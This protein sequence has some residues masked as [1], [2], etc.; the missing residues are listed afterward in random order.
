MLG[1]SMKKSLLKG[2]AHL[3]ARMGIN[4]SKGQR[5]ELRCEPEVADFAYFVVEECYKLGA[6]KVEVLFES[7]E[8]SRLHIEYREEKILA[9]VENWEEERLK[10]RLE[11]L[12]ATIY[13][14][15][16]DPDGLVGIDQEKYGRST[17]ER[18]KVIKP[19]R[20][21]MDN[22]YPWCIAAVPGKAWAKKMFPELT[23]KKAVER[24][25]EAILYTSRADG[26]NPVKAWQ[27]HNRSLSE[28][29]RYLNS[30]GIETLHYVSSNGT[31]LT[32]GMIPE[33]RF[34]AGA[35]ATLSG[36]VFNPNIPSEEVFIS[37]KK[38]EAEGIVYSSKP[39]SYRGELIENFSLRF[40]KGRVVE[41]HA[42]KNE[43]LLK[44][45][46]SMDEGASYLGECALVPYDSPISDTGLLFYNTL[47]DEN[48]SCHLA[49][50]EGFT[51]TLENYETLTLDD[52]R[53]LGINE[54]MVHEDFM[55]GTRD[56]SIT[57]HTRDGREV[58][59]FRNGNWA[60]DV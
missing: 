19:Y 60:F 27:E 12:P 45:L 32:V 44:I 26:D 10:Y 13:L 31:D 43:E 39:L 22:K 50:G 23:P 42:E 5:V 51:N 37:P 52:C 57:A 28:R 40:E 8:L 6:E 25:W 24:L 11:K 9:T 2:Y 33:A 1:G 41:V 29:C 20:D 7:Q 35:E 21:A 46:V 4:V 15:S 53:R 16:E 58:E 56:L 17:Q 47:F 59:I 48:A 3:I 49:L 30:L 38:G 34:C 55:I 36:Q 14:L 54:S 18:Y